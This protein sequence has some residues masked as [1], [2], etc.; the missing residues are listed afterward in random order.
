MNVHSLLNNQ[1]YINNITTTTLYGGYFIIGYM[2][3]Q[4]LN[5]FKNNLPD[6]MFYLLFSY[7]SIRLHEVIYDEQLITLSDKFDNLLFTCSYDFILYYSKGQILFGKLSDNATKIAISLNDTYIKD[8]KFESLIYQCLNIETKNTEITSN[9]NMFEFIKN[10]DVINITVSLDNNLIHEDEY[11]FVIL[12]NESTNYKKIIQKQ[13]IV[14]NTINY[15]IIPSD[16][17]F[18]IF[19]LNIPF[20]NKYD[21]ESIFDLHLSNKKYNFLVDNNRIDKDFLLFF[22]NTYYR[23]E[24]VNIQHLNGCDI[25]LMDKNINLIS[26]DLDKQYICIYE[27]NYEI[28]DLIECRDEEY[29]LA[30][31]E[32]TETTEITEITETTVSS[33][34]SEL[35]EAVDSSSIES[36]TTD[37]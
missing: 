31:N 14:N 22:I 19:Q 17:S 35:S 11:D 8:T 26:V 32:T 30:N 15:S 25:R 34:L 23:S 4:F 3:I 5:F 20:F 12:S 6:A 7:I 28:K 10:G 33:E 9:N 21:D 13:D 27:N 29:V 1:F 36:S 2:M 37:N 16:V 18:M 24:I